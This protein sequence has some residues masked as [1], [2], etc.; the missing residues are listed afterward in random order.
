MNKKYWRKPPSW[1]DYQKLDIEFVVEEGNDVLAVD[2]PAIIGSHDVEQHYKD[3][4][5]LRF[6]NS[7]RHEQVA[8]DFRP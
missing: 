2:L 4:T 7:S 1:F 8:I 6:Q 3:M 5:I